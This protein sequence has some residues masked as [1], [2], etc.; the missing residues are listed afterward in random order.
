MLYRLVFI[1]NMR[2][3]LDLGPPDN[4]NFAKSRRTPTFGELLK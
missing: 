4:I 3:N 2:Q 1:K